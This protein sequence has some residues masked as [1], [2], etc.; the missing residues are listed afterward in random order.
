MN[1]LE[2]ESKKS[3]FLLIVV[4]LLAVSQGYIATF[5]LVYFIALS[6]I[7]LGI[8]LR[9]QGLLKKV[10]IAYLILFSVNAFWL[11]PN[12]YFVAKD[13]EINVSAKMNQISSENKVL[14]NKK[15][16]T[17]T[18][19]TL[20]KGFLFENVETNKAGELDYLMGNWAS[21]LENP[22]IKNLGYSIFLMSIIGMLIAIKQ[23]LKKIIPFI[24]VFLFGFIIL[25]NETPIFSGLS[26][27]FYQLPLVSQIFRTPF[28]KLSL[29][30]A[31]CLSI[32]YPVLY[33]TIVSKIKSKFLNYPIA[34]IFI[35]MPI[36][37][38]YPI[39]QSHLLYEKNK[40]TIPQEY[41]QVFEFFKGQPKNSRIANFPQQTYW[42]WTKYRWDYNGSGF[43]WYGI[44]QPILDRAFDVWSDKNENY[45]WEISYALYSDNQ[46]LFEQVLEKYQI[47]WLLV[48][49]NVI[50]PS[51]P[52]AL[53]FDELGEMIT[54]SEKIHLTQEFNKIKI[55]Q[56]N[57]QT[58][59]K[60]FIFLT[61]NLPQIEPAYDWNNYDQ[62]YLENGNYIDR[63]Y[64][65]G[66]R[67]NYYP[68]RSL[69]TGRAQED[70]EFEIQEKEDS[71]IIKNALPKEFD[72][73]QLFF[74]EKDLKELALTDS[75]PEIEFDG[76]TIKVKISKINGFYSSEI[77]PA[78]LEVQEAQN[79]QE[80]LGGQVSNEILE[81]NDQ[82]HLR[83]KAIDAKNCGTSFWLPNLTHQLSYFVTIES[84]NI[85]GKSLVFWI[86]NLNSRKADL[87]TYLLKTK[88]WQKFV[89]IQPPMEED[90]L[91]YSLH[92][93]NISIGRIESVNDLGKITLNPFPFKFLTSLK[94]VNP[95]APSLAPKLQE[96]AEVSHPNPSQYTVRSN[97]RDNQILVLSQAY[98]DGWLAWEGV[99]FLSK[100][101]EHVLINN[102]ENGW[103]IEN[104]EVKAVYILFWPQF[105]E[106]FGFFLLLATLV[107]VGVYCFKK[108]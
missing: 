36:I 41:F 67:Q 3:L 65:I 102:W 15:Y 14:E 26:N 56:V 55:Y 1:F 34:G 47:N 104:S 81:E 91:G 8:L 29:L 107:G 60:D 48:D 93:D 98:H 44:E 82:K 72:N 30:V 6:I 59:A 33:L 89:F 66:N 69:F 57:L 61:E 2:N 83:L 7:F 105:L 63:P 39:F 53:Y 40:A 90:G 23:R 54:K 68:F 99:P 80:Y 87:E 108:R 21:H 79:C 71:F 18:S 45:Y 12:L 13:I 94:L 10:L 37:F 86:E 85:K 52:K 75:N 22:L 103:V 100:R 28:T 43:L 38:L 16:G 42:G 106:Y 64:S 51:S 11:L 92:F 24:L 31:F 84:R 49:S 88:E 58:P 50:N 62:A 96:P 101:L 27:L 77:E 9:N 46:E 78:S 32:F 5:F 70:L 76:K 35:I 73:Y 17:L 95:Q 74:P 4:N 19:T 20:L 97:F 25:S